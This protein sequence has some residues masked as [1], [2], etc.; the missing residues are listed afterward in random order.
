MNILLTSA[1]RRTYLIEYFKDALRG[2]GM[3][4]ASNS[5]FTPTLAAADGYVVTPQIYD[6][7][8]IK[9]LLNYCADKDIMAVISLFDVDLPVLASNRTAFED[10]GI[11]LIVSNAEFI[12]ICNDK[13]LTYKFF[14]ENNIIL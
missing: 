10:R 3:V 5:V 1:G 9:F 14:T 2:D 13:F 6:E 7:G 4:Y 8:Y 12:K 11:K